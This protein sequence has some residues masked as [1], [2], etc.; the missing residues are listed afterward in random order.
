MKKTFVLLFVSAMCLS[1]SIKAQLKVGTNGCV[2]IGSSENPNYPLKV[3][4]NH[5][6]CSFYLSGSHRPLYIYNRSDSA[7][8]YRVGIEIM[9]KV[10]NLNNYGIKVN[11]A[12][13]SG[14]GT[15]IGV[16]SLSGKSTTM[17]CGVMGG[18]NGT[19]IT[20]GAGI[21]GSSSSQFS[22]TEQQYVGRYA[23]FFQGDVRVTGTLY[24]N[25][26]TPSLLSGLT[27]IS[28]EFSMNVVSSST[29]PTDESV[30]NK[31]RHIPLLRVTK[32]SGNSASRSNEDMMTESM[33]LQSWLDKMDKGEE[34]TDEETVLY[35]NEMKSLEAREAELEAP[36]TRMASTRYG[37][38]A[39][40]LKAVYPELV[41]EDQNG[42]VSVNY[43]E[44]VPLLVQ[45]INELKSD[46]DELKKENALLK[47]E[48]DGDESNAKS[49]GES[50]DIND[51]DNTDVLSLSQ[52]DPN[53]FS[54]R[55]TISL[56]IPEGITTAAVFFYDMSGKQIDKRMITERG[57][58]Q[59]SVTS[60]DF[61][62][63][64][65]LYS[66][67]ADGKVV[68]TRKMILTK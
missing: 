21:I 2:G 63:G 59:I 58:T 65:Y 68:A 49:R 50:T 47:S 43:I 37:L 16:K 27:N 26:L 14:T 39:D 9:N 17:S 29:D 38:D 45:S 56:N 10:D 64:M 7:S 3:K 4:G 55:T 51:I 57:K 52:N 20:C 23:G 24:S 1:N 31:F 60:A 33:V 46:I 34:L 66:L 18:L 40:K 35:E 25:V 13:E 5:L 42:N 28:E 41:Y 62:E 11:A 19:G 8:S 54:E 61:S 53:P 30:S 12:T 32:V 22:I 15:S 36:Q 6:F 44:M 67:I 48:L